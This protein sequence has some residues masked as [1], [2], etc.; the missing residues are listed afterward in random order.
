MWLV[1]RTGEFTYI[2][3]FQAKGLGNWPKKKKKKKKQRGNLQKGKS[4]D[5]YG[6]NS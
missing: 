6:R 3:F 2:L 4:F 1:S 5:N